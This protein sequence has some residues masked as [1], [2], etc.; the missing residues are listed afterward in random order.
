MTCEG[1][2]GE[3]TTEKLVVDSPSVGGNKGESGKKRNGVNGTRVRTTATEGN[4]TAG[5]R[6]KAK[7]PFVKGGEGGE[8]R[9]R[10]NTCDN[11]TGRGGVFKQENEE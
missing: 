7:I 8:M 11:K 5:T 2:K 9:W 4:R 10:G 3:T 6:K 1:K